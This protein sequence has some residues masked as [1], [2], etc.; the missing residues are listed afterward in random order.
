[1]VI[2]AVISLPAP[3]TRSCTPEYFYYL[4]LTFCVTSY[5]DPYFFFHHAQIDRVYWIWQ[6]QDLETRLTSIAG[7]ITILN[8]P[9]SRNGTLDDLID[10]GVNNGPITIRSAMSTLGGPFCYIYL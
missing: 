10:L 7:T 9:P 5:S 3:G 4:L 2:L 8:E 6:N 1:M